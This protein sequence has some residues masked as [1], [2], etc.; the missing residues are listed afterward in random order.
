MELFRSISFGN[1]RTATAELQLRMAEWANSARFNDQVRGGCARAREL[2]IVA[3][4]LRS[5]QT[6]NQQNLAQRIAPFAK[7]AYRRD[8]SLTRRRGNGHR[9]VRANEPGWP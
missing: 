7:R 9:Q 5:N 1:R 3:A 2:R 8:G 4:V 6:Q